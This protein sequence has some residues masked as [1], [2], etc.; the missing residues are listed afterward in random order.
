[1]EKKYGINGFLY[2]SCVRNTDSD[3]R[4]IDVYNTAARYSYCSG[5]GYLVYPGK[6]YGSDKP[7]ASLRLISHRESMDDYD[8][9]SVYENLLAK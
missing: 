2:W 1:M 3:D 4:Y 7:F 9:L 5:E 8:M 6:Y